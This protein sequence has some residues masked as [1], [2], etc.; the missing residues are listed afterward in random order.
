MQNRVSEMIGIPQE[1]EPPNL[2]KAQV[3]AWTVAIGTK[4][5]IVFVCE[6]VERNGE[7]LRLFGGDITPLRCSATVQE[8]CFGRPVDVRLSEV[9]WIGDSDS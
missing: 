2:A 7:W 4:T 6:H 1:Y 5:G 9:A 8:F 3:D